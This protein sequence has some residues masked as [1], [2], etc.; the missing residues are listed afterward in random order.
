MTLSTTLSA[1]DAAVQVEYMERPHFVDG[2]RRVR[3]RVAVRN[4]GRLSPTS[5]GTH[6][7]RLRFFATFSPD[8]SDPGDP[9][10]ETVVDL[11]IPPW[12]SREY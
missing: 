7:Y 3:A 4:D 2:G 5:N 9:R 11:D 1:Q 10:R 12:G 8:A 6:W